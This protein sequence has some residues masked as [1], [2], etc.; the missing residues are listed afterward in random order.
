MAGLMVAVRPV[1]GVS[2]KVTIPSKP[3]ND[4]I[5]SV[6]LPEVLARIVSWPGLAVTAKSTIWTLTLVVCVTDPLELVTATV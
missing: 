4:A 3:F 1:D 5:A 2:V 6:E